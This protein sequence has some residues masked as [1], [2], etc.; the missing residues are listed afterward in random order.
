MRFVKMHGA[1]NDYVYVDCFRETVADPAEAA[2]RLSDR[3]VGIGGDGLIL[4]APSAVADARMIMFN[5]DGSEAEMCG[6][7]VRCVAKYVY[8]QIVRRELLRIETGAGVLEI[9]VQASAG[10]VQA[11]RVNMGPPRLAPVDIPMHHA[12]PLVVAEPL[13]VEGRVFEVTAVSMGNPHCVLYVDDVDAFDV[14]RWGPRI[15][16]HA[17]FPRRT[18]VEFVQRLSPAEV[19]QRTW[20]R[21]SGETLACGTGACAVCVAGLLTGRTGPALAVQLRGGTLHLEWAGRGAPVFMTGPCV[22]VFRGE[23]DL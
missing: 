13:E 2:R 3:H 14:Q 5:A 7:G 23:I 17:D 10:R 11:A 1:G 16:R 18:N 4:I 12:K 21:G 9:A 15:E 6:N 8:E 22:E 20:E 19:R